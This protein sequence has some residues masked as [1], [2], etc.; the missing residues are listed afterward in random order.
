MSVNKVILVGNLGQDPE[1]HTFPSGDKVAKFSIATTE[2]YKDKQGQAQS[3]TEWH[4]IEMFGKL[5]DLALQYLK[6][7]SKIYLEGKIKTD[8]WQDNDGNKRKTTK[9]RALNMT[10]L[11]GNDNNGGG[12][13]NQQP[14]NNNYNQNNNGGN[15]QNNNQQFNN[16]NGGGNNNNQNNNNNNNSNDALPF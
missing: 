3:N 15:N 10:F 16:N 6:K 11:G 2:K 13:N 5:A 1:S 14:Q 4:N 7:G 8:E 12:N 9:I